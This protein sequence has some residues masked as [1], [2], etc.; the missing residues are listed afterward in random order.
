MKFQTKKLN[1]GLVKIWII[2]III[3]LAVVI[4]GEIYLWQKTSTEKEPSM[5]G[6]AGPA[7]ESQEFVV[8]CG[9]QVRNLLKKKLML[10]KIV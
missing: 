8:D 6:E 2:A 1:S 3:I 5:E 7:E 4:G 9:Q 10:W